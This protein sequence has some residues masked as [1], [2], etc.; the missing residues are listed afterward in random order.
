MSETM[1]IKQIQSKLIEMDSKLN[2]LLVKEEKPSAEEL[3]DLR[4]G[5]KEIVEGKLVSW[6]K[7]KSEMK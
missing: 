7:V 2:A 1:A 5:H 3:D 6:K 4:K